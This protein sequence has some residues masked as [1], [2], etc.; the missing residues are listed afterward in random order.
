MERRANAQNRRVVRRSTSRFLL[1]A[2]FLIATAATTAALHLGAVAIVLVMAGAFAVVVLGEWLVGREP[3]ERVGPRPAAEQPPEP[4]PTV[5]RLVVEQPARTQTAAPPRRP[6][7]AARPSARPGPAT[8]SAA[9]P[10]L[11]PAPARAEVHPEP[12]P[13]RSVAPAPA[14][15]RPPPVAPPP[16]PPVPERRRWN[17]YDLQSRARQRGGRDPAR[18]EELSF[19]LLYLRELADTAGN[20]PE[21]LDLFVRASFADLIGP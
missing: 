21:D 1:Q 2:A 16:P 10:R 12:R 6:A 17:I 8:A 11:M 13:P 15:A 4:P 3:A 14:P 18:D 5:R 9:A 20:L 19:L 7:P